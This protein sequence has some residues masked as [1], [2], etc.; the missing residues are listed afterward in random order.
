MIY[1]SCLKFQI[2]NKEPKIVK[3]KDYDWTEA[4]NSNPG[5][6]LE[7][8]I[9]FTSLSNF[10]SPIVNTLPGTPETYLNNISKFGIIINNASDLDHPEGS[11]TAKSFNRDLFLSLM[12]MEFQYSEE[13]VPSWVEEELPNIPDKNLSE[14]LELKDFIKGST[15]EA[16][17]INT[18]KII[19]MTSQEL[20]DLNSQED[21]L[22]EPYIDAFQSIANSVGNSIPLLDNNPLYEQAIINSSN[23]IITLKSAVL[24]GIN[25]DFSLKSYAYS[26]SDSSLLPSGK[27]VVLYLSTTDKET[28]E[29][30]LEPLLPP[31]SRIQVIDIFNQGPIPLVF[32]PM[33]TIE[34]SQYPG[35]L[36]SKNEFRFLHANVY[37]GKIVDP[38]IGSIDST[39]PLIVRYLANLNRLAEGFVSNATEKEPSEI[40][41]YILPLDKTMAKLLVEFL[42]ESFKV[43]GNNFGVPQILTT[44]G[45]PSNW[46]YEF[47]PVNI[48]SVRVPPD[49]PNSE[50]DPDTDID[51]YDF[52][53]TY[54]HIG[55]GEIVGY[56]SLNIDS[57]WVVKYIGEPLDL[58]GLQPPEDNGD[59]ISKAEF[60][61]SD[62]SED[63]FYFIEIDGVLYNNNFTENLLDNFLNL[64][65]GFFASTSFDATDESLVVFTLYENDNGAIRNVR[66]I[67]T[68]SPVNSNVIVGSPTNSYNS[69]NKTLEF[70]IITQAAE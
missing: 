37:N 34:S 66:L 67:P 7:S 69:Q 22:D 46:I 35:E 21:L 52:F 28:M 24:L 47:K 5:V 1:S 60:Y 9:V 38:S 33:V 36:Y 64:G 59:P 8:L 43:L 10:Y 13:P 56:E 68:T 31:E 50:F 16:D 62:T 27:H 23:D 4:L 32:N 40:L 57:N 26:V 42:P 44:Y 51:G 53:K 58:S 2:N 55:S 70:K 3:I 41:N 25:E 6:S 65:A 61:V 19:K 15:I 14:F 63:L 17:G 12:M 39:D 30:T 54:K 11:V 18:L 48:K 45:D 20:T 49:T 29:T